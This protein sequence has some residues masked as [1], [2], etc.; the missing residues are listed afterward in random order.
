MPRHETQRNLNDNIN[1][2]IAEELSEKSDQASAHTQTLRSDQVS[3]APS[4]MRRPVL[5]SK[6]TQ[7]NLNAA[8]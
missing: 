1:E 6:K 4:N 2:V 3:E 5:V 8:A 7:L